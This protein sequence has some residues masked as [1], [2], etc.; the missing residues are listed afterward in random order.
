MHR[1]LYNFIVVQCLSM[2]AIMRCNAKHTEPGQLCNAI[3][4]NVLDSA[5]EQ[6]CDAIECNVL[7]GAE[8][9]LCN[10]MQDI[11]N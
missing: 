4:C 2:A 8:D 5:E 3:E 11:L 6:L 1:A 10:A 9:Q 7:N